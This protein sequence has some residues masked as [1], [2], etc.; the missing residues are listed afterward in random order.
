MTEAIK[1]EDIDKAECLVDYVREWYQGKKPPTELE[2]LLNEAIEWTDELKERIN[3]DKGGFTKWAAWNYLPNT[4]HDDVWFDKKDGTP[5]TTSQ[6]LEKY[7][8]EI[9]KP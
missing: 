4:Q 6:L 2:R 1:Q 5:F 3:L 9:N 8:K 7:L